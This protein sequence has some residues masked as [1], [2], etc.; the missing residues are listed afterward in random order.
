MR[1]RSPADAGAVTAE[2]AIALP[3]ALLVLAACL[4]GLRLGADQVRLTDA[5]G[6]AARSV[7]RHDPPSTAATIGRVLGARVRIIRLDGLVCAELTRPVPAG[8]VVPVP[9]TARSCALEQASW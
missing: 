9:L 2:L 3:A 6:V 4:G 5:A 8:G 1:S 7:A